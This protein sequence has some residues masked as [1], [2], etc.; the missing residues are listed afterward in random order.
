MGSRILREVRHHENR[1]DVAGKLSPEG[2]WSSSITPT[3]P[4]ENHSLRRKSLLVSNPDLPNH[5]FNDSPTARSESPW[6]SLSARSQLSEG[7]R[8]L[9]RGGDLAKTR[10]Q[11]QA[12]CRPR[13]PGSWQQLLPWPSTETPG[14]SCKHT[15]LTGLRANVTGNSDSLCI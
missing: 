11:S 5:S 1:R 13:A 9:G 6:R 15:S 14:P 7:H 12:S 8:G 3:N 4:L 2:E 10:E